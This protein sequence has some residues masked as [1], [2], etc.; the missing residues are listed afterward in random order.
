MRFK[1]LTVHD[2][3]NDNIW[4]EALSAPKAEKVQFKQMKDINDHSRDNKQFGFR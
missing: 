1:M 4:H 3:S 2:N